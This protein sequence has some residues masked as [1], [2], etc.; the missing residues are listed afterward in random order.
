MSVPVCVECGD[1]HPD[2]PCAPRYAC[3]DEGV[4][5]LD[6]LMEANDGELPFSPSSL[7]VLRVG[8]VFAFGGGASASMTFRRVS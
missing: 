3:D 4:W 7:L 6:E 8:E 2:A 5:T 1:V